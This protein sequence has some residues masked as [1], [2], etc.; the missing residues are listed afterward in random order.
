[1][2]FFPRSAQKNNSFIYLFRH[3]FRHLFR[4]V[5][6]T[7]C[8]LVICT[9]SQWLP[10]PRSFYRSILSQQ[11]SHG[12][13][14]CND[15]SVR[16]CCDKLIIS[17]NIFPVHLPCCDATQYYIVLS[18]SHGQWVAHDLRRFHDFSLTVKTFKDFFDFPDSLKL[19][20]PQKIYCYVHPF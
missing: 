1:M 14:E 15:K 12:I 7:Y 16:F 13:M 10:R 4:E 18:Q 9:S 20:A 6:T 5:S 19:P 8:D 3:L 11:L 2:L 17:H